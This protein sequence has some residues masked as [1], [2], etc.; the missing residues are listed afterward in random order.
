MT[1]L[2]KCV[3][4]IVLNPKKHREESAVFYTIKKPQSMKKANAK[5]I[6]ILIRLQN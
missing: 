1:L 5:N 6:G 3:G 4:G 2:A